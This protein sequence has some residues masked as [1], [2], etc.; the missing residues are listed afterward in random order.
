MKQPT[1]SEYLQYAQQMSKL[2]A[3][4]EMEKLRLVYA[5]HSYVL[6]QVPHLKPA[7]EALLVLDETRDYA[8]LAQQIDQNLKALEKWLLNTWK[9]LFEDFPELIFLDLELEE[10][11]FDSMDLFQ[12]RRAP[13][14]FEKILTTLIQRREAKAQIK[15]EEQKQAKRKAEEKARREAEDQRKA[16]ELARRE[17]EKKDAENTIY[18]MISHLIGMICGLSMWSSNEGFLAILGCLVTIYCIPWILY[19]TYKCLKIYTTF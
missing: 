5:Q 16:E 3:Q 14:I 10:E 4:Q 6:K 19:Y 1:P 12:F 7:F 17:A 13:E 11:L 8:A 15:R 2:R 9:P 18:M